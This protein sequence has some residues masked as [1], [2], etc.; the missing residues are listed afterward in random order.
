MFGGFVQWVNNK[1]LWAGTWILY[2][3]TFGRKPVERDHRLFGHNGLGMFRFA[4][5]LAVAA[6]LLVWGLTCGVSDLENKL[7]GN[8]D[9]DVKHVKGVIKGNEIEITFD[10]ESAT[11]HP[12]WAILSQYTDPG[13]LPAA[14]D[15]WGAAIA[16]LC[17]MLGIICLS[18]FAVS[19]FVSFI[20]RVTE[21]W[22]KGLLRYNYKF[23]NYVVIIGCNE[24]TANIVKLSLK[25]QDVDYV[26]IQTRQDVEAMRMKLDLSLDREEEKKVVFY[27]AERTSREDIEELHLKKAKEIYI[28]GEGAK[29]PNEE[30]HDAYNIDCLENISEYMSKEEVKAYRKRVFNNEDRIRCHVNLE[31]QGTFT[32]F[33]A[34]HI[35]RRLDKDIEF[36]PFNIHELW[37]KKILVDN[38]AIYPDGEKV[39]VKVQK[40]LPIDGSD[41]IDYDSEK[42]VHVVIVGMNQMGTALGMQAALLAHY[43]NFLRDQSLRTTITFIDDHAKEE[44]EYL[45]GRFASLFDLCRYKNVVSDREDVFYEGDPIQ[46][47]PFIDPMEGSERYEHL[48]RNFMDLQWE[49]IQGNVAEDRV[50]EYLIDLTDDPNKIVTIAICLNNPQQAI[51]AALYLPGKIFR[52]VHQVLVYQQSSFDLIN[53]VANGELEW[54]RYQNMFPFG[55][56]EGSYMGEAI[57]NTM[58][59]LEH[60]LYGYLA[61][62]NRNAKTRE[63]II[64]ELEQEAHGLKAR[65]DEMWDG[66]G[67]VQKYAN[68]DLADSI[69]TKLRSVMGRNYHGYIRSI[70]HGNGDEATLLKRLAG[71][72]HNRWMTER[73][74]MSFRPVAKHETRED[75]IDLKNWDYFYRRKLS[76]KDRRRE[77]RR[78]I[79]KNRAHLDICPY[80]LLKVVDPNLLPNDENVICYLP[81][82]LR[83]C[84][85]INLETLLCTSRKDSALADLFK[86]MRYVEKEE[87]ETKEGGIGHSFWMGEAPITERQWNVVMSL[88]G[89]QEKGQDD[90][91]PV[92]CKSKE[93]IDDFL[94]VLRKKTGLY[95]TLPSFKEWEY[96]AKK[97]TQEYLPLVDD[98]KR[99]KVWKK[100]LH[101]GESEGP[102]PVMSL[103]DRQENKLGLYDMLGNVWEWTRTSPKG[104]K[105][106]YHFCGGS[107]RFKSIECDMGREYWHTFWNSKLESN[108]IG[109]RVV[110]KYEENIDVEDMDGDGDPSIYAEKQ[111]KEYVCGWLERH[112]RHVK[113]GYF[114]M[115]TENPQTKENAPLFPE[116]WVDVHAED[117]EAPHHF[118]KVSDFEISSIPVTQGLWNAVMGSNLKNN[119][120]DHKG[121]NLPQTNVSWNEVVNVFFDELYKITGKKFRLPT[122]AE[123]EY[124]AK[125]GR[126]NGLS[127]K[128]SVVFE[129]R[130]NY[131]SVEEMWSEAY[132]IMNDYPRYSLFSGSEQVEKVAWTNETT[133]QEVG[134]K[135]ANGLG[136]YDMSGNVWEWCLDYYKADFYNDCKE[137]AVDDEQGMDYRTKGFVENP[138]CTDQSYSAHVFRG[139]SWLF[140]DT[141]SRVTNVN[142]WI[143]DDEDNDLGFRIVMDNGVIDMRRFRN[144]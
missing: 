10:D 53:K 130:Q 119:P 16:L 111:R 25:R 106:C 134:Q 20:N 144:R 93:E 41:G 8:Y 39:R 13:N 33:K 7:L 128:L 34:T 96:A 63:E 118:V 104:H 38:F 6:P 89:V 29:S 28:L 114:V 51:A 117:A 85:R 36:I 43:P 143:E 122:E 109:F 137:G 46:D 4:F 135:Q 30:D 102:L 108:D 83:L 113:G 136:L 64:Q 103:K 123:W 94:I 87:S 45:R 74:V 23:E 9:A 18:G 47:M 98:S 49:F 11:H 105:G 133:T 131:D 120:S 71:T 61:S 2:V 21:R 90:N 57:D 68:I 14:Q 72:E 73:L 62:N 132:R 70:S 27:Y 50:K 35:Y 138:V 121:N 115:G 60:F 110:W 126:T 82:L 142:Y 69:P 101:Y 65:I 44:G 99:E 124:A 127:E 92:V 84:E 59:K 48:G 37:A 17:A 107:W 3:L 112:V 81:A 116:A 88:G 140:A 79:E 97:S 77:K 54:K 95:F 12:F 26:L 24:Q 22:K 56:V 42:A 19:S 78:L 139:G 76:E 40:Y 86:T 52:K 125:G 66:L 100:Y 1:R 67:I 32:A 141:V 5:V 15:G 91:L 55:M 31:Y 80:E 129:N 58:A 75:G